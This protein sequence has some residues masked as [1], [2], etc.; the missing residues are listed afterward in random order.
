MPESAHVRHCQDMEE[1]VPRETGRDAQLAK[2]QAARVA[3]RQR[4]VSPGQCVWLTLASVHGGCV[5]ASG[6]V[7]L[8]VF[9][10]L[11]PCW[12]V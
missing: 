12:L 1:M 2:K 8:Y 11:G 7:P 9:P 3:R 6:I 5:A 4:D 10:L